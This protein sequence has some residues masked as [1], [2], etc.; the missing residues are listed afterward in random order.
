[1]EQNNAAQTSENEQNEM[2][3]KAKAEIEEVLKKYSIVLLPIVVHRG[4]KTFS[5]IDIAPVSEFLSEENK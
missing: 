1:M 3:A 2:L 5:R 4:D